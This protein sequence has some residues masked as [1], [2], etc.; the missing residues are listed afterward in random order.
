MGSNFTNALVREIGRN[1]GKAISNSLL[2]D[3]HSTPIRM[4]GGSNGNSSGGTGRGQ[5]VKSKIDKAID[6]FEIKGVQA[7]LGSLLNIHSEYFSI[8]EEAQSD[9]KIDTSELIEL[10]S[11]GNKIIQILNR[12]QSALIDL[13]SEESSKKVEEKKEEVKDFLKVL[14]TSYSPFLEK[15]FDKKPLAWLFLPLSFLGFDML[16]FSPKN[17]LSYLLASIIPAT[18]ILARLDLQTEWFLPVFGLVGLAAFTLPI[19]YGII[20]NRKSSKGYWGY[21]KNKKKDKELKE[22]FANIDKSI[23]ASLSV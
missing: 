18:L 11:Y 8:V 13:G 21:I 5:R 23:S 14:Q 9:G 20:I 6:K 10:T 7:T 1:Y 22:F 3:K 17:V 16:Y 12:G 2:G 15:E 19:W 4:T